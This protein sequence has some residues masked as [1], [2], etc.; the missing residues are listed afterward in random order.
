MGWHRPDAEC[1][2]A[3][4]WCEARGL[5]LLVKLGRFFA[6][7][8]AMATDGVHP[9][10]KWGVK[11]DP[12]PEPMRAPQRPYKPFTAAGWIAELKWD[13]F[14]GMARIDGSAVRLFHKSRTD[15][16]R[17]YPEVARALA[18]LAGGPHVLDGEFVVQDDLGRSDFNAMKQRASR[19]R[20]Y[21]GAP[22]VSYMAFDLLML[23][24]RDITS[25]PLGDR[26]N[27]LS[28]LLAPINGKGVLYVQHFPAEAE[29]FDQ[30]VLPL[31][32]EGLMMKRL[33]APYTSGRSD[34]WRKVKRKGAVEPQRFK[35]R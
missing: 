27:A 1:G 10:P 19:R 5:L 32:L 3:D 12:V 6:P 14:R 9:P 16:T 8:G 2:R 29:L 24:G 13:G 15:V 23:N 17:Y 18:P 35:R 7:C 11:F 28:Q 30:I 26:K 22:Q 20:W 25:W 4:G 34:N 21:P 33:D 31:K